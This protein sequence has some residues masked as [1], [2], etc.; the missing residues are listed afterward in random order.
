MTITE[1]FETFITNP[2][3]LIIGAASLIEIAPIKL[4]PWS[5]LL[6]WIGESINGDIRKDLA[7]LKR[8]YEET[9]ASNMRWDILNFANS[10]RRGEPHGSDEWRHAISQIAE[11]ES[12]TERKNIDNGVIEEDTKYLRELYHER[13]IKN[14]FLYKGRGQ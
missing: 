3:V 11:Y 9:K 12:Y 5:K 7:E 10:C 14:D 6:K 13:N 8:D 4:N 2:T 1:F